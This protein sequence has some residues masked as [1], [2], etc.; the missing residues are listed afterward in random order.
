MCHLDE[1]AQDPASWRSM[2]SALGQSS[3]AMRWHLTH[4][5]GTAPSCWIWI[6]IVGA[7]SN[8]NHN[9]N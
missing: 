1:A 3:A 7:S 8:R 4:G 9:P 2:A 6:R 5:R